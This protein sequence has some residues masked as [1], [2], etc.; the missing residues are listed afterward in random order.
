MATLSIKQRFNS[1]K[2]DKISEQAKKA[3]QLMKEATDNF[4]DEDAVAKIR[5]KFDALFE[6]IKTAKP[7][8]IRGAAPAEF[9]K[10]ATTT[11]TKAV[12]TAATSLSLTARKRIAEAKKERAKQG[13]STAK[14]DIEKDGKIKAINVK[15]RRISQGL[16]GNKY[17]TKSQAKGNVYYEYRNNRYDKRPNSKPRLEKGG[18]MADGGQMKQEWVAVYQHKEKPN[19]KKVISTHGNTK[20]EATRNARMSEGHHG[21]NNK[22]ELVDIYTASGNPPMMAKGGKL[23][24]SAFKEKYEKNEDNNMHSE[25]VVLLAKQFGTAQDISDAK[26][27][28]AKHEAIGHLPS[29]LGKERDALSSKLYKKYQQA[30]KGEKMEHGGE[31][32]RLHEKKKLRFDD[33]GELE[34]ESY[35]VMLKS[36]NSNYSEMDGFN[37]QPLVYYGSNIGEVFEDVMNAIEDDMEIVSIIKA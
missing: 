11:Q 2:Q 13:I 10:V 22:F 14:A 33:G 31:V 7:D 23:S 8:A 6:K 12:K 16:K 5:P 34:H 9:K 36:S 3:L 24:M 4:K 20:M 18:M 19:E 21:I 27:I 26:T 28:Q 25:N 1:I 30:L 15:G 37:G 35:H 17:A 32:H 29:Y